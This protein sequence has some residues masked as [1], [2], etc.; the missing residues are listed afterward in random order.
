MVEGLFLEECFVLFSIV[1]LS[2]KEPVPAKGGFHPIG[3]ESGPT[4]G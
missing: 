1:V 3:L 4:F 2:D